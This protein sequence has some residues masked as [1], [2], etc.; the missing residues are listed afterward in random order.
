MT[1]LPN[2]LREWFNTYLWLSPAATGKTLPHPCRI[3]HEG[4]VYNTLINAIV[5]LKTDN[6]E[7]RKT[8]AKM[9]PYLAIEWGAKW[10]TFT[11]PWYQ[12]YYS[13]RVKWIIQL[14]RQRFGLEESDID[15]KY[16]LEL[17]IKLL[18][19]GKDIL[20]W[21][22]HEHEM[23]LG[24]CACTAHNK[25]TSSTVSRGAQGQ[26]VLGQI[27]M[28]VREDL[29]KGFQGDLD[30]TNC[31][32]CLA[33]CGGKIAEGVEEIIYFSEDGLRR[34]VACQ[35]HVSTVAKH[36]KRHARRR[37]VHHIPIPP[38]QAP[39]QQAMTYDPWEDGEDW[40]EWKAYEHHWTQATTA[41]AI[42]SA[43]NWNV[44][45]F[46]PSGSMVEHVLE[47]K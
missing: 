46:N 36:G 4:I 10:P 38:K 44:I 29:A 16:K 27:M 11:D 21:V 7:Q 37:R 13:E 8:I 45:S 9:A 14:V 42:T 31:T 28:L 3:E 41:T 43:R 6:I 24:C 12:I 30:G 15:Y 40:E 26:N 17:G 5:A 34:Y 20:T 35:K 19:T 18:R 33:R 47:A 23:Y 22:N 25:I 32:H 39:K 1:E 2:E